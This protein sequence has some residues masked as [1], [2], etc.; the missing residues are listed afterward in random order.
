VRLAARGARETDRGVE[1][2]AD[3]GEARALR[4]QARR[5]VMESFVLAAL[6]TGLGVLAAS[7]M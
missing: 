4:A 2:V 6:L 1:P 5:I 3:P 7:A